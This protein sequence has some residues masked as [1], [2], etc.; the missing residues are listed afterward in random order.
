MLIIAY[1]LIHHSTLIDLVKQLR[2]QV[3]AGKPYNMVVRRGHVLEDV[4]RRAG[5]S[6]FD[7]ARN[8]VVCY[9]YIMKWN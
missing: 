1:P 8:I 7:P 3:K 6:S 5:Q 2:R 9:V 4:L